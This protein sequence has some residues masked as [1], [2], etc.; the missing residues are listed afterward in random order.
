MLQE[1]I[2]RSANNPEAQNALAWFL[3]T[4]P[5]PQFRDPAQAVKLAR[6]AVAQSPQIGKF[7]QTLGV[8]CYRTRDW[9]GAVEALEK[10]MQLQKGGNSYDW[11]F[12]A[13][14]YWQHG[15]KKQARQ[16]YD[17]AVK[18]LEKQP[19]WTEDLRRFHAEAAEL[20]GLPLP[21]QPAAKPAR[22]EE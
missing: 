21:A 6:E 8:A 16:W 11:F 1:A 18:G 10:S 7:A 13:M 9:K 12:L 5:D 14:A 22:P 20:F 17:R 4:C 19:Q 3:A 15:D 2:P